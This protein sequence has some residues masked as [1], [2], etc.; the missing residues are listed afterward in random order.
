MKKEWKILEREVAFSGFFNLVRYRIEH[1]LFGGGISAPIEREILHRGHAAA[2][3]PYD[4]ATDSVLLIEQFRAGAMHVGDNPWLLE[5]VAG[6]VEDGES[7]E[8]VVRREAREEAGIELQ[9]VHFINQNYPSP[10]GSAET[11]DLYWA[12]ADLSGAG[13]VFGL[14]SE[15]EDIRATV[16]PFDEAMSMLDEGKIN[17]SVTML[18]L[19]WFDR[20]RRNNPDSLT[21][22]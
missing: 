12:S 16:H 5:F 13:G 20:Y 9:Q 4:A 15:G 21:H 10:G 17:N 1:T 8:Q 19:L 22:S 11:I 18:L 3:M 2:V 6:M 7:S 14:E